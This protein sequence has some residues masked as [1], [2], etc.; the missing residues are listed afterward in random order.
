MTHQLWSQVPQ[1]SK[2]PDG[3]PPVVKYVES[4]GLKLGLQL[5]LEPTPT[6]GDSNPWSACC[7]PVTLC[8]AGLYTARATHTC[9]GFAASCNHEL[10]P[11]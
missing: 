3:I 9:A 11:C 8:P 5:H 4:K 2:F 7:S 6:S 10:V 1:P